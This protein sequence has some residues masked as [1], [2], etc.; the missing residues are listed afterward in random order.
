MAT[1]FYG[2]FFVQKYKYLNPF[3]T[4]LKI[5]SNVYFFENQ[6]F[7]NISTKM[8]FGMGKCV[9]LFNEMRN[10]QFDGAAGKECSSCI[11]KT[12]L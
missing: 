12:R 9:W 8:K 6:Y 1:D 3:D 7:R 5:F 10:F 4:L 11:W 2:S